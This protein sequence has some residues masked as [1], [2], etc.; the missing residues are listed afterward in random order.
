[1]IFLLCDVVQA[2]LL[3][4]Y[5]GENRHELHAGFVEGNEE[6]VEELRDVDV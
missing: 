6:D 3:V 4:M 1:M 5:Q 2:A